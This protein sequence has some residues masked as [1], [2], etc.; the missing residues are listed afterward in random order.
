M[1][2][3]LMLCCVILT[4]LRCFL[5]HLKTTIKTKRRES[6]QSFRL[7]FSM[8]GLISNLILQKHLK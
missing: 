2:F 3:I 5:F 6:V 8:I 7:E 4:R 1:Y